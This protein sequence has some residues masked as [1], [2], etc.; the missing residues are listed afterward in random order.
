MTITV[1]TADSKTRRS[2]TVISYTVSHVTTAAG[3]FT[4]TF[5]GLETF[6]V[7]CLLSIDG[8]CV[9]FL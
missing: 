1:E 4:D 8:V 6:L 3:D 7:G 9:G 5:G 2:D